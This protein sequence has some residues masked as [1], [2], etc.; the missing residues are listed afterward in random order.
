MRGRIDAAFMPEPDRLVIW[1]LKSSM[2]VLSQ[3][4]FEHS[5]QPLFYAVLLAFGHP[6]GSPFEIGRGVQW[7]EVVNLFP[8]YLSDKGIPERRHVISRS[9]LMDHRAYLEALTAKAEHAFAT[10]EW[11]AVPG[12]HCSTCAAP[13]LCP[14]PAVLRDHQGEITTFEQACE[15]ATWWK[16]TT[17]HAGRVK[18]DLKGFA[19]A[20]GVSVPIGTDLELAFSYTES[21]TVP[22]LRDL[23]EQEE[24]VDIREHVKVRKSTTFAAR[25]VKSEIA[26]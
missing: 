5:F 17:D 8:R 16:F 23:L 7:F 14:L 1:D 24:R 4:D 19:E 11:P 15:A 6:E 2:A 21:P 18:K 25:K 20:N 10:G 26:A 12:S 13:T 9:E 22:D 3:E